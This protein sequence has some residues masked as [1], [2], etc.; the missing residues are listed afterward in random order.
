M[1]GTAAEGGD[2]SPTLGTEVPSGEQM[3]SNSFASGYVSWL[4]RSSA[5]SGERLL[6]HAFHDIEKRVLC[7]PHHLPLLQFVPQTVVKEL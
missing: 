2:K 1:R 4:T 6:V 3:W 7:K 5:L